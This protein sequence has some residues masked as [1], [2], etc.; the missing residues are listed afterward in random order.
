MNEQQTE[1]TGFL[2]V[3][4][5]STKIGPIIMFSFYSFTKRSVFIPEAYLSQGNYEF[6]MT[7]T[8]YQGGLL[9]V[10]KPEWF[11]FTQELKENG[12][13]IIGCLLPFW[14]SF[15]L[16]AFVLFDTGVDKIYHTFE[17]DLLINSEK[18]KVYRNEE[19]FKDL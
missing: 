15:D 1:T 6:K 7:I 2:R 19:Y 16:S 14:F 9:E 5:G 13:I 8:G 17:P 11:S 10:L 4:F 3:Q 18:T 12:E